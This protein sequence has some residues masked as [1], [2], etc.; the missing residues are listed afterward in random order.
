MNCARDLHC[1]GSDIVVEEDLAKVF[2]RSRISLALSSS[3]KTVVTRSTSSVPLMERIML[4]G[5]PG[6]TVIRAFQP[7]ELPYFATVVQLSLLVWTFDAHYLATALT[8]ALRNRLEGAPSSSVLQTSPDRQSILGVLHACEAQTSAFN[9]SMI[10]NAVSKTLGYTVDKAPID[11]PTFVLQGLLDMLPSVQKWPSERLI[12]IRIPVGENLDS[13]IS[14]LVV[15]AH[16][17]LDLTVLVRLRDKYEG[18]TRIIRFG[19]S[20]SEQV[21]IEEV[22]ADDEASIVLLDS[23]REHLL[24]VKAEPE[25]DDGLIGSVRRVPAKGWGN[26]LLWDYLGHLQGFQKRSK[27]IVE[28]LQTITSTFAFI[29]AKHLVKDDSDRY[30][31]HDH[32]TKSKQIPHTVDE[33][34]LLQ[35]SR[36][37]F[38]N[39]HIIREE[40]TVSVGCYRSQALD[41]CLPR[42]ATL[43]AA[44]RANVEAKDQ[45]FVSRD[46][47]AQVCGVT[48]RLCVILLALAHIVDLEDFEDLKFTGLAFG[49]ISDHI[50]AQ[51]L[52]DWNGKDSLRIPDEAWLQA[53]AIPLLGHRN[54]LTDLPWSKVCLISDRRWSA[55]ISTF[56]DLD[57]AFTNACSVR[58]GRGSPCRNGVWKTGIWDSQAEF[59]DFKS[60]PERAEACGQTASLHCAEKVTMESPYC[61]EGGDMFV[62]CARLRLHKAVPNQKPIQ[63][64]GYKSLQK[65]LWW[66]R[67]SEPCH[68]G[69]RMR[70]D[71]ELAVGCA[72]IAGFGNY[73]EDIS[74]RIIIYLT[75]HNVGARWLALA[76]VPW[77]TMTGCEE[78]EPDTRQIL[79]RGNDC[80]FQCAIDQAAAQ[81]GKWYIIL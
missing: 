49:N 21:L 43:K 17:V 16:H 74:E 47:W 61:G 54:H 53:L 20:D 39:P 30:D 46:E 45:S 70:E 75:A 7:Q 58:L 79:L 2:G 67:V 33:D 60:D 31:G 64:V 28:E 14:T 69:S 36:F 78:E 56:G 4:Q 81:A 38:D 6:P 24:T 22:S 35:A 48:K 18:P 63:R 71:V 37:L 77:L 29:V 66:A 23:E 27:A 59:L 72:T 1:S 19:D 8:N 73:L 3:F 15:W 50:L 80:C 11:F 12:H 34:R 44:W 55:W 57:P 76:T 9:W 62:V 25:A 32:A 5:G 26:A 65:Y 10:L 42:P 51:Q 52:E 41:E 13:G 40:I 68:H